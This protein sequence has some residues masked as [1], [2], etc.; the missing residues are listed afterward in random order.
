VAESSDNPDALASPPVEIERKY[1][2]RSAP[3]LPPEA[4]C[5]SIEQGYLPDEPAAAG[6]A[7]D[8]AFVEGRLRRSTTVDGAVVM[9]HTIK[10]GAGVQRVEIERTLDAETFDRLWPRTAGRRLRKRRY[11]VPARM[12]AI[13]VVWEIDVFED[14]ALAL[15]EVELPA[16]DAAIEFP[17]WLADRIQRE[18]TD[19][20]AYR[21]Y[22][23]A[24]AAGPAGEG[25]A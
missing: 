3:A 16:A 17:P 10:R 21:N 14:R 7:S 15:A 4:K 25:G 9:T 12:G 23:L 18:V 5:A 1:L 19:D 24:T 2:L 11:R 13:D 6:E 22:A 8:G 20:P